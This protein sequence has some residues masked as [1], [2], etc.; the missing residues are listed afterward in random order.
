MNNE[1][2]QVGR[3]LNAD[4]DQPQS[5]R[6]RSAI[7][8]HARSGHLAEELAE[9]SAERYR[10]LVEGLDAI[11]WEANVDPWRYSFVSQRTQALLGYPVDQWLRDPD[12]WM[13]L[14]HPEDR[15][16][17]VSVWQAAASARKD[18]RVDYR[19][20]ASDGRIMCVSMIA[21]IRQHARRPAQ[22][23]G[24]L[25]DVG[26]SI[27][28]G[29]VEALVAHQTAELL[30]GQIQLRALATELG[31]SEH[32]ERAKLATELHDHLPNYWSSDV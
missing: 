6:I 1:E 5:A 26:D 30:A 29:I 32:R 22:F 27:R 10:D 4:R 3:P 25:L 17:T 12:F 21:R 2:K 28:A 11:V 9:E 13:R 7:E 23:R 14:I 8:T 19:V 20:I 15:A 18:F 24:L 16:R 31:L